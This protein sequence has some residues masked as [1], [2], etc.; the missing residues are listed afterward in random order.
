MTVD[1]DTFLVTVYTQVDDLYRAVGAPVK[2]VRRGAR[3]EMSD[4]EVLTLLVCGQWLRCAE[5]QMLA[6]AARYWRAYFPRLLHQSAFNRRARDLTGVLL[7]LLP[8]LADTLGAPRAAYQAVDGVPVPLARRCRGQRHRL[9]GPEAAI[10]KGGS[11]RDWYYGC[12]LLLAVT[13]QG[14]V[15]GF[16]L[17]PPTTD[18]RWLLDALLTWRCDPTATLWTVADLPPSHR[19]GGERVGPTGPIWPRAAVGGP[20]ARPYVSDNGFYGPTAWQPHWRGDAGAQVL[21]PRDLSPRKAHPARRQFAGWRQVVET[22][23]G[24]LEHVF[25]LP[26]P[27]AKTTWGLLTRIAAKLV[28]LNLGLWLNRRLGRPPFALASLVS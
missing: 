19:A 24:L 22:V 4:S 1:L 5:G 27:G 6:H 7:A 28:A 3:A 17:G 12:E 2:P 13:D 23:N 25:G 11:D 16:V 20:S 14:A 9:F 21:T 8:R 10:G 18:D 15:T 26:Y